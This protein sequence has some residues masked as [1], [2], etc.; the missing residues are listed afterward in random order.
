M[1]THL[2]PKD[3]LWV[4]GY[5]PVNAALQALLGPLA[6]PLLAGFSVLLAADLARRLL[7]GHK[8]AP[9]VCALLMA[10]SSQL[11]LNAMTPYAMSAH[12]AVNLAWLWL[13]LRR[14][15]LAHAA[16]AV[17]AMLA[18]GLHQVVFFPLFA[19]PFLFEAFLERRRGAALVQAAAIGAAFLF[20]SSYDKVLVWWFDATPIAA[21]GGASGTALLFERALGLAADFGPGSIGV[22]ALNLLRWLLWQNLLAVPLMLAVAVPLVKTRGVWRAML[23]GMLLTVAVMTVV[24][25]FSG[26]G[27]GYRYLHGFLGSLCLL[28]TYAWFRLQEGIEDRRSMQALFAA[29]LALSLALVPFA[30][31][32]PSASPRRTAMPTRRSRR[33]MPTWC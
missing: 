33:S 14:E 3:G 12:V 29:A 7:P 2:L 21:A 18:I 28:A 30:P 17:L 16:A 19:L 6:N 9:L 4:S 32:R 5:M 25:A 15:W 20:W 22:M 11:L 24:L 1:F 27:W 31:G 13:F 8:S 23:A 10:S 26:H